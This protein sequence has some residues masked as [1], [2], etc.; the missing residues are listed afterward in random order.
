M[1]INPEHSSLERIAAVLSPAYKIVK[2]LVDLY[3]LLR[4]V[5]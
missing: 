5:R 2:V 4:M 3:L 1:L